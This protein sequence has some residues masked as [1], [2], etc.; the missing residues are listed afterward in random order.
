M[1]LW[2]PLLENQTAICLRN[3][4]EERQDG[5]CRVFPSLVAVQEY[6]DDS[7]VFPFDETAVDEIF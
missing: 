7:D 4:S 2:V 3:L 1:A 5:S 6:C